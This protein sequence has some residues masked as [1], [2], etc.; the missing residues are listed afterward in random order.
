MTEVDN[1]YERNEADDYIIEPLRAFIGATVIY[2]ETFSD[3]KDIFLQL[4]DT[5]YIYDDLHARIFR[6][7]EHALEDYKDKPYRY[8]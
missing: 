7:I 8:Y 1:G 2:D 3:L 4:A 5:L 6:L